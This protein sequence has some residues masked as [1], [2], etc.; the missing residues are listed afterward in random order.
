MKRRG[1]EGM[2]IQAWKWKWGSW[3]SGSVREDVVVGEVEVKV[4]VGK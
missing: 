3:K 2:E 1:H 4:E